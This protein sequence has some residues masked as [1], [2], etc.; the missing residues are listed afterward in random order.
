MDWLV[1][2]PR[3]TC[4]TCCTT[5]FTHP[6]TPYPASWTLSMHHDSDK[7][8]NRTALRSRLSSAVRRG[9]GAPAGSGIC[10]EIG[11]WARQTLGQGHVF[12]GY[13]NLPSLTRPL[14]SARGTSLRSTPLAPLRGLAHSEKPEVDQ[15]LSQKLINF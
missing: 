4:C 5:A 3:P 15:L 9:G 7:E 1:V 6:H 8:D 14:R 11:Q 2:P 10:A 13:A 12:L